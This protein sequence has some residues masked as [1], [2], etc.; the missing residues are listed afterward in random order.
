VLTIS[1]HQDRYYPADTGGI[2]AIGAGAGRGFNINLPLPPGSGHGAYLAAF[3]RVVMRQLQ[4]SG[5]T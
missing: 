2:Q 4:P 3:E 5:R 1:L